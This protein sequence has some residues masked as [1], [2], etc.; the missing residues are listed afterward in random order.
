MDKTHA[1]A[2]A[3]IHDIPDGAT[4]LVGGFGLSGN[5]ENLISAL[6]KRGTQGITLVSNNAGTDNCGLGIL[7]QARQVKTMVGSYVGENKEFERQFL[8]GELEVELCPQGTLA[9]RMRAAGAGIPAFFTPT[10]VGTKRAE[11]RETREFD[12]RTYLMEHALHGDFAF[13]KAWKGDAHGNLVFRKT[14]RNFNPLVAK[15]AKVTIAEV[16]ELVPAGALD[17]DEIHLPGIYVQR[18]I[19]GEHYEKWIEQRT[20]RS[21]EEG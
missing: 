13:V 14:A 19:A 21:R 15:A 20:V 7:L 4:L 6:H 16:E 12:G 3:A 17:P 18:I 8:S 9:E 11:G 1:N 5:P 2:D 10:G